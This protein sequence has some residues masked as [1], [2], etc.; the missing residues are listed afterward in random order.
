MVGPRMSEKDGFQAPSI[1]RKG[2][3]R[4][5]G[6]PQTRL[7]PGT[8]FPRA[9]TRPGG[10]IRSLEA[11][12]PPGKVA[13][14]SPSDAPRVSGQLARDVDRVRP[15]TASVSER[16]ELS[17]VPRKGAP[18]P[19]HTLT[20]AVPCVGAVPRRRVAARPARARADL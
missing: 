3:L 16:P 11:R 20:L 18:S 10:T 12:W 2:P 8:R 7:R 15:G 14:P 5:D 9:A 17:T 19:G 4:R 1:A 13:N 6:C